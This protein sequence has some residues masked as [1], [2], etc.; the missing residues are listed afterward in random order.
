MIV[1]GIESIKSH[2]EVVNIVDHLQTQTVQIQEI[3]IEKG[4]TSISISLRNILKVLID[5]RGHIQRI[6]SIITTLRII[7]RNTKGT[8][9]IKRITNP[10]ITKWTKMSLERRRC[11]V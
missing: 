11:K 7:K 9:M 10:K 3:R 8:M 1:E 2:I 6:K 4:D 5:I